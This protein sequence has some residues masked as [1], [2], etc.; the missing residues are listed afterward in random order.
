MSQA[1]SFLDFLEP[2]S[3]PKLRWY[4]EDARDA[5]LT[6]L[7]ENDSTLIVKATGLGKC[8]GRG[9]PV[10]MYDGTV[11]AVERIIAG[12]VL[13]G[14]DSKPR[15][16]LRTSEGAGP[17]FRIRP[18]KGE[19]WICNDAHVLTLVDTV[20]GKVTDIPLDRYQHKSRTWRH[21]HKLFSVAVD[22]E[23]QPFANFPID[24]YILGLW[25]GDGTKDLSSGFAITKP[26]QEVED[27]IRW[28]AGEWG[29]TVVRRDSNGTRCPTWGVVGERTGRRGSELLRV[30]RSLFPYAPIDLSIPSDYLHGPRAVRLA[31]LAGLVDTDGHYSGGCYEITQKNADMARTIA[32]L[33]RSLGLRVTQTVKTV[34]GQP[35]QRLLLSGDIDMIPVRIPR[36]RAAP[37]PQKKD[38]LRTGFTIEPIG[39]GDYY[40]F[41]LDG[42]GRFLL[43]DFTVTHNTQTFAGVAEAWD[44]SVLVLAHRD[45]LV[46]QAQERLQAFTGEMVEVEQRDLRASHRARIVVGS[47]QSVTRQNRLDRFGKDRFQ[48]VIADEAHHYVSPTYKRVLDFFESAKRLG[49]TATPDRGDELALGKIFQSVAYCMDIS[50]G[51]EAGYLV[52]IKGL[53]VEL[54][55]IDLSGVGVSGGDL[56]AGQLDEAMLRATEGI[57]KGVLEH[58]PNR[59]GIGF[60]P[61]IKTADFATQRMNA[62]RPNSSALVTA[63]TPIEDRRDIMR[64]FK[65]GKLQ[66]LMNVG[67]ATEGFDAPGVSL[68]IM[69]RPTKSRALYA[70]MAGRGTRVLPGTIE[71]YQGRGEAPLRRKMIASSAK[72]DMVIMDFVGNAGRHSLVGPEDLLG[73]NYTEAEIAEAKK[74]KD[75]AGGDIRAALE[76]ARLELKRIAGEMASKVVSIPSQFDPFKSFGMDARRVAEHDQRFGYIPASDNQRKMLKNAGVDESVLKGLS[77]QA[78]SKLIG[79]MLKRREVG[80]A[81]Y[82]QVKALQKFGL[83]PPVQLTQRNAARAIEYLHG[84]RGFPPDPSV[85]EGFLY[86]ERAMG[87]DGH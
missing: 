38:A 17:L 74:K 36:K 34:N 51:I 54:G 1:L 84:L 19:P 40:G 76:K 82:S 31:V 55:T 27:A 70:Q 23:Q 33:A 68:I 50:D 41:T 58:E 25:L 2:P 53:S 86:G 45:E 30:M 44:G 3:H 64:Q 22:F 8:L 83:A 75:S 15:H 26:D 28:F 60:F 57:V 66:Y 16:V 35:Y 42:D 13:M 52:P 20:S 37:R 43:G 87:D 11:T 32:F 72:P 67:V 48:L 14:P 5:A 62:L 24:P 71:D 6:E 59:Q 47:V 46:W 39:I 78:A 29:L 9:T 65:A 18:T 7:K 73:G 80:L 81:D 12:D 85:V 10:L 61:G 21:R 56:I 63:G 79:A 77:K 4:Q 69:G 49:V